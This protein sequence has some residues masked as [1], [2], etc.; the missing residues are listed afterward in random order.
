MRIKSYTW[1][2][3]FLC[4]Y[5]YGQM[6]QY[7]YKREL[8][9]VS[10][11]WHK[12][13]LPNDIFGK[14]SSNLSDIRIFGLTEDNDTIE[15]P[16]IIKKATEKISSKQVAFKMLNT[17][18][19]S[20]GYYFTFKIPT[21]EA[22]NQ[23]KLEFEQQNYD[24]KLK[25]EGSQNQQEWFTI[26]DNYRILSIKNKATD[27]QFTNLVFPSSKYRFFRLQITSNETP[28]L[29]TASIEH[30]EITSGIYRNYSITNVSTKENKSTKQTEIYVEL[31]M[32]VP[33]SCVNINIKDAFD[34][35]R[36]VTIKYL[37]DSLNTE[38]GWKY[39]YRTLTSETLN[40]IEKNEFKFSSV[41]LKKLKI[42][43]NNQDNQALTIDSI[44]IKGYVHELIARFT[45]P[46]SY[47]LTYKN[48]KA[49]K[50]HYDINRFSHKIPPNLTAIAIGDEL[51]INKGE[52]SVTKPLFQN[53]NWLW[54]I[55][56][57][58]ILLL[59]WFSLKMMRKD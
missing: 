35:Y 31:P 25:L 54:V 10:E 40:S 2:L 51:V 34:Y 42:I 53:K 52:V 23:I 12:V 28:I 58:I 9:E 21:T 20:K 47:F 26:T 8:T 56:S 49:E 33:V 30:Q 5:S 45:E 39:I 27:F 17:S 6:E 7:N 3:L 24:W 22:I 46:A 14:V 43:I 38:K 29:T 16:Y 1:L 36:P 13:V 11:Q 50:P 18:S 41:T 48:N 15:V 19:N 59:G 32:P 37:D 4:S 57:V 55:M 44:Q